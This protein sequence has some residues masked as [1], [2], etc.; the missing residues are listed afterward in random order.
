M[1]KW[2]NGYHVYPAIG[3]YHPI[4]E[5]GSKTEEIIKEIENLEI[6]QRIEHDDRF[7]GYVEWI[8][9]VPVD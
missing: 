3:I 5:D 6:Y 9:K 8:E 4:I 7:N 2:D 1:V